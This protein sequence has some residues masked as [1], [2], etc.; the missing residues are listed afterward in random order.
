MAVM[1]RDVNIGL[2]LLIVATV[3]MFSGFTVYYQTTFKNISES[4]EAKLDELTKVT[5]DLELKRSLLNETSLQL[6]V[7]QQ[8]EDELNQKYSDVRNERDTFENDKNKL[9]VELTQTKTELA[10]SQSEVAQTKSKLASTE[11]KLVAAF[12]ENQVLQ[13]QIDGLRDKVKD[14][15]NDISCLRSKA[16][17]EENSC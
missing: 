13:S 14:L 1:R 17:A 15:E 2:L 11:S 6:T 9:T 12:Q 10:S 3:I 4:Y 16:D 7:R 8:R 5:S